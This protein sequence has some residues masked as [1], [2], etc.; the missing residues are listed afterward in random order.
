MFEIARQEQR[1]VGGG[2][3]SPGGGSSPGQ[4]NTDQGNT[5][6]GA[7]SRTA[8]ADCEGS[9]SQ[10]NNESQPP[11]RE[12]LTSNVRFKSPGNKTDDHQGKSSVQN[13]GMDYGNGNISMADIENEPSGNRKTSAD[14]DSHDMSLTDMLNTS[15]HDTQSS[16]GTCIAPSVGQSPID[17]DSR[18]HT[19]TQLSQ[20][21]ARFQGR[22]SNI[23]LSDMSAIALSQA[24]TEED[25]DDFSSITQTIKN[26]LQRQHHV[27]QS[28]VKKGDPTPSGSDVLDI[29]ERDHQAKLVYVKD[30][31][32]KR[33]TSGKKLVSKL[34]SKIEASKREDAA[35]SSESI[36]QKDSTESDK[37]LTHEK[38]C[39]V[40]IKGKRTCES[41]E[42]ACTNRGK[43]S[44]STLTK[45]QRFMF[46]SSASCSSADTT[47]KADKA[48]EII[49]Q[50]S[51]SSNE[52]TEIA[53]GNKSGHKRKWSGQDS[54]MSESMLSGHLWTD[55]IERHWQSDDSNSVEK[56]TCAVSD[57]QTSAFCKPDTL[58]KVVSNTV[59]NCSKK[60][61]LAENSCVKNGESIQT[62]YHQ[63]SNEQSHSGDSN[64][65]CKDF[66]FNKFKFTR[67]PVSSVSG[68]APADDS[69]TTV[70]RPSREEKASPA[71]VMTPV[72]VSGTTLVSQ[73]ST[74]RPSLA[75]P[76]WLTS[77]NAK[78]SPMFRVSSSV[79][80][81]LDDLDLELD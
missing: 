28:S 63:H 56:S 71:Q 11:S 15:G 75:S 5:D 77:L 72:S 6:Q 78:V 68:Q 80:H 41:A 24:S 32:E 35:S 22:V 76:A 64:R 1:R 81:D 48:S 46:D 10:P 73:T 2:T 79:D 57:S 33:K 52:S 31:K 25:D 4:G 18:P 7:R 12:I 36:K 54:G 70:E 74:P 45:L 50:D 13:P 42:V 55:D 49:V 61:K 62:K 59:T 58:T 67:K 66:N 29:C 16:I 34:R 40:E 65:I 30:T 9:R 38:E 26:R 23:N 20:P 53:I 14:L 60:S 3:G 21:A 47:A 19:S 39:R 8:R 27:K 69:N 37:S 44:D 51:R 17:L 43:L